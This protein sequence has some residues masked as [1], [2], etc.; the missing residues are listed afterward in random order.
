MGSNL[1]KRNYDTISQ[2]KLHT[3][4]RHTVYGHEE[5]LLRLYNLEELLQI[6]KDL[7]D[8]LLL[9]DLPSRVIPVSAIVDDAIH[10]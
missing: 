5:Q 7:D 3:R 6:P 1:C 2:R 9:R 10:V 4:G 8:H